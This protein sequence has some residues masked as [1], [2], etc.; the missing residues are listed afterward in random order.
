MSTRHM[1]AFAALAALTLGALLP[2]PTP[3]A[4]QQ[5]TAIPNDTAIVLPIKPELT[6]RFATAE[7]TWISLD[8]SPDGKTI[9]FDILGDLYTIPIA[10]GKPPGS[11]AGCRGT[12]C[13]GGAP[14]GARSP[15][16]P[17]AAGATTSGS[18][19]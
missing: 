3:A 18:W 7:A 1:A 13:R 17:T 15:S 19:T 9:V 14:T 10:G 8:V 4:A 5:P 11:R 12:A 6:L 16:C 2:L